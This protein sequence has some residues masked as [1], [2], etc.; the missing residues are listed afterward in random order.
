MS[1]LQ[2]RALTQFDRLVELPKSELAVELALLQQ[3]EPAL[4]VAVARL[5][6]ADAESSG[7]LDHGVEA[8]VHELLADQRTPNDSALKS[9]DQI[10]DFM[11]QH[12]LGR[13]GMGEVWLAKR[14]ATS[15][16]DAFSQ[17]VAL[18]VL[19]RGMDSEALN[20]RFVQERKILA[21]LNHPN[22]ARFIDGGISADGR[23]YFAMEYVLGE[24]L[25]D[26][27]NNHD[28]SVRD[29]VRLMADVSRA[30]AYAQNHLIVHR[31]LKPSNILVDANGQPRILDFGIAKL[32]GERAPSDTLTH[33]GMLAL[34][35]AYAA[36]EQILGESVNTATDVYAL[37]TILFE[38]LTGSLPH[39]R[40][41]R[42]IEAL[43]AQLSRE[44]T[45]LP[46]SVIRRAAGAMGGIST[47]RGKR[48]ITGDLDTIVLTAL[49]REPARRYASAAAFASDLQCWLEAKP[50]AAQPDSRTYRLKKFV[51]RNRLMVGS[52]STVLLALIAGLA[53][54]LWQAGVAREQAKLANQ[55]AARAENETAT[56]RRITDFALSLVHELNPHSRATSEPKS[57]SQLITASI[58]RARVELKSDPYA[59]ATILN[60]LGMLLS[61][62][63]DLPGADSAVQEALQV[64]LRRGANSKHEAAYAQFNLAAIRMQQSKNADAEQLFLA[65]IPALPTDE[66]GQKFAAMAQSHL[67][68]LA[69]SNG[70]P[71]LALQHLQAAQVLFAK[72]WG[73]DHANTI[74]LEGHRAI[75]LFEGG[76]LA[77]A[78]TAFQSAV[79]NFERIG[80]ADFPRLMAPLAGLARLQTVRG[81]YADAR[82][83]FQ[84]ALAIGRAKMGEND[85]YLASDKLDFVKLLC[86]LGELEK[87]QALINS[88]DE[89]NLQQRLSLLENLARTRAALARAKKQFE[90]ENNQ[91]QLALQWSLKAAPQPSI[92]RAIILA[93]L[94]MN[95]LARGDYC[96]ARASASAADRMFQTLPSALLLDRVVLVAVQN[97]L[98]AR[99]GHLTV[100]EQG[101]RKLIAELK[102][103]TSAQTLEVAELES[104]LVWVQKQAPKQTGGENV[105]NL[106][107]DHCAKQSL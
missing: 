75:L 76:E 2:A 97:S 37:G 21:E 18:K 36:P 4:A 103:A 89:K 84:R 30:V 107:A 99:D 82:A 96:A 19:K 61:V 88:I 64:F 10:G 66:E 14:R 42:S 73:P 47:V 29:R 6:T 60:K 62:T 52:A 8:V 92:G 49:K 9:D 3:Q 13:G 95:A 17:H 74:E 80:G 85:P 25:L 11:L 55:E 63:G 39:S 5:L 44:Q 33:T 65:S 32:L 54:A 101:I 58:E 46:S 12:I 78:E 68:R 90:E 70:Q 57:P 40:P 100:A 102:A 106:N 81:E 7:L 77:A 48:D 51:V 79:S 59:R 22:F 83:N 50:I 34:S 38:L 20:A 98:L 91:L 72:A 69:R 104:R 23:L 31:D 53:V 27:A 105:A 86:T 15:N 94:A 93:N 26:Y 41:A 28:L 35:P 87:A 45:P 16:E 43:V 24:N 1:S 71:A 67:A 56:G